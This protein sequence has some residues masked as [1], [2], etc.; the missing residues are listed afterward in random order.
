M[1]GEAAGE[2]GAFGELIEAGSRLEAQA[3]A[4]GAQ[5]APHR[6]QAGRRPQAHRPPLPDSPRGRLRRLS[7]RRLG[8]EADRAAARAVAE[9]AGPRPAGRRR[10]PRLQ[11]PLDGH[12]AAHRRAAPAPP[13]RRSLLRGPQPDPPDRRQGRGPGP[14]AAGLLAQAD[15]PARHPRRRRADQ[16]VPGPARAPAA[17]GRQARHPLRQEP[18]AGAG[19]YEPVGNRVDEPGGQRQGRGA[20]PTGRRGHPHRDRPP[21]QGRG[22]RP[23]LCRPAR[24]G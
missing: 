5:A 4:K 8:P 16:R 9:D 11:Q 12:R 23:R 15:R 13:R 7:G 24:P 21:D 2:G 10:R 20:R 3:K 17:R 1:T 22:H 6:G 14:Q 18:A 19:R